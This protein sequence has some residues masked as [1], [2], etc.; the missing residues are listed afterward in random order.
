VHMIAVCIIWGLM[1][2]GVRKMSPTMWSLE[3]VRSYN[4]ELL[5]QES[6]GGKSSMPGVRHK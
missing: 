1:A 6:S 3:R 4:E 5:Q 2:A